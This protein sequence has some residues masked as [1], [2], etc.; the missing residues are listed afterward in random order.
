MPF[1]PN[2]HKHAVGG[3]LKLS[4]WEQIFISVA[5]LPMSFTDQEESN[6]C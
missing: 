4:V 2:V 5:S 6:L 1:L 3:K